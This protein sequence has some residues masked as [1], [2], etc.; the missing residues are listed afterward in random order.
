[1]PT[2]AEVFGWEVGEDG[3]LD[4]VG[5]TNGLPLTAAGPG[6]DASRLSSAGEL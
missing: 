6:R 5:S 1:M 2:A 4:A 3:K